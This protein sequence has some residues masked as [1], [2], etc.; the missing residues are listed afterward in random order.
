MRRDV[1]GMTRRRRRIEGLLLECYGCLKMLPRG[2]FRRRTRVGRDGVRRVVL[3]PRCRA[4]EKPERAAAA[5]VRRAREAGPGYTTADVLTLARVQGHACRR[6]RRD[7]RVTGY[8]VDHVM[9]LAKGGRNDRSNIQL[10]CPR[11]NLRK[12]ARMPALRAGSTPAVQAK[13]PA[14]RAGSVG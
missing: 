8:H 12:A 10:L 5:A 1:R 7:L 9:P 14:V 6:C 11:C 4:C 13:M 3:R 2:Q